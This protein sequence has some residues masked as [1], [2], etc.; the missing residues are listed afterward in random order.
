MKTH[1]W[2][3]LALVAGTLVMQG[4]AQTGDVKAEPV[5]ATTPVAVALTAPPQSEVL[6][7]YKK[8]EPVVKADT[9][10]NF[11]AVAAAIQQQMQPGGRW[12]FVDN[13][14]RNTIDGSFA[15]MRGLYGKFNSVDKMDQAAK[16]RLLA[17][18]STV[19]AI[20]T[21]RDGERLICKSETP[22][23]SHLPVKTC[24]TYA[25]IQAEERG[26]Q[27]SLMRKSKESNF[28]KRTVGGH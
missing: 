27:Q 21:R 3:L 14:E 11:E 2:Y 24:R 22:V 23:G 4:C 6:P 20:L 12:Q 25:Q 5:P 17:A 19:N 10:E 7:K 15:D 8:G 13:S 9:K 18:Q 1:A 26:A 16:V 28:Q